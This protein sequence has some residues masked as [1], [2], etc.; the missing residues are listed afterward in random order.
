MFGFFP[1]PTEAEASEGRKNPVI[2]DIIN[3]DNFD[4]L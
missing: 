3:P 4:A 1:R 2:C